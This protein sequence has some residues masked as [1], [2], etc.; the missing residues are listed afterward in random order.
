MKSPEVP[1]PSQHRIVAAAAAMVM[2]VLVVG[3]LMTAAGLVARTLLGADWTAFTP[4]AGLGSWP[5]ALVIGLT[6]LALLPLHRRVQRGVYRLLYGDAEAIRRNCDLQTSREQLVLAR[7]AERRRLRSELHD[8][9]GASFAGMS[10]Q[11]H[12]ALRLRPGDSR[13]TTILGALAGD[14]ASCA[15]QVRRLA[16]EL[17]PPALDRGLVV[18]VRAECRRFATEALSVHCEV[19]D[20]IDELPAALEVAAF[21]IVTAALAN[22]ARHS[23]ATTC[24]VVL[25]RTT[26]LGV[27]MFCVEIID[28]GVGAGS[29]ATAGAG[30]HAMWKRA[31]ELGGSCRIGLGSGGGT[32]VR[33]ELPLPAQVDE[34]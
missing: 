7:E 2:T 10:M 32:S 13:Q 16:E 5:W 20:S 8:G 22:V 21:R 28:D 4:R 11:L 17:R 1:I 9:L 14:L 12:A 15:G 3:L 33:L 24:H 26:A 27:E 30:L 6:F 29:G 23:Q 31:A 19:D 34:S 18:A 25:R